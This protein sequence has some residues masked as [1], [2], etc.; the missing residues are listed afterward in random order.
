LL[1][2]ARAKE[3]NEVVGVYRFYDEV[4]RK[5]FDIV[6][7]GLR[8]SLQQGNIVA[9][10]ANLFRYYIGSFPA[11]NLVGGLLV[12]S[13][14][15]MMITTAQVFTRSPTPPR[16]HLIALPVYEKVYS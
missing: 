11:L 9:K 2:G 15:L 12:F 6:G 7:K 14:V 5:R 3:E 4:E 10:P 13:A 1:V 16:T 8:K